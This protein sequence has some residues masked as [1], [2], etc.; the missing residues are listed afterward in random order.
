ME[1]DAGD[2]EAQERLEPDLGALLV[3]GIGSH[4]QGETLN[5]FATPIVK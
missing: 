4:K 3:H 2:A 5:E 1:E